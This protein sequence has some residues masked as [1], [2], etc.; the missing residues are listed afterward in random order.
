MTLTRR[1][2]QRPWKPLALI[3]IAAHDDD[4]FRLSS[5]HRVFCQ[6]IA[7]GV[8]RMHSSGEHIGVSRCFFMPADD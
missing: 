5:A 6:L 7:K 2:L 4:A 8:E 1:K 3:V